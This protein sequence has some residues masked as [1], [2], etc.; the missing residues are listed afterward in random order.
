MPEENLKPALRR[1]LQVHEIGDETPYRLFFAAKGKSGASFG[2]MQG[3]LAGKQPVVQRTFHEVLSADGV[4]EAL[5]NDYARRLSVHLVRNPLTA[6]ETNQINAALRA[7]SARVDAMDD[8]ILSHVY[9]GLDECVATAR[10]ARRTILP[11]AQL[12]IAMW[13][14]MSGPPSKILSWLAGEDAQLR[15][16]VPAPGDEVDRNAIEAYLRATHYFTENPRNFAHI[17][18]SADAGAALLR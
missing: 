5:I 1:A 3:D 18:E 13:I 12:F 10:N 7:H 8:A 2:F 16:P 14:N 6:A 11:I 17:R 9:A 15:S 4:S